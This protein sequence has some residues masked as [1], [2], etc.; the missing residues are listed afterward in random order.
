MTTTTATTRAGTWLSFIK[1]A[2]RGD[3]Y[4]YTTGSLRKAVFLLAVPMIIE[5]GMESVFAIVDLFFVGKLGKHAVT[6]VGLTESVLSLVY[7]LAIGLSMGATAVV[8]RRIG[9]KDEKGA[10]HAA[11]QSVWIGVALSVVITIVGIYFSS[12]LLKLMGAEQ[13]TIDKGSSYTRIL[14]ASSLPIILL[15]LINGIFR[16]AGNA[17]I[18]MKSLGLANLVN[19]I[20]CPVLIYGLGPIPAMGLTGAA[21]A[22]SIGRA[23]GVLYQLYHLFLGKGMIRLNRASFVIDWKVIKNL[24]AIGWPATLQFII[25]SC[26]WIF[27]AR[28][29]A[30]T[31]HSAAS[32]GYQTAMRIIIF[33]ILPAW[34]ISNASATLVGQNLG[35]KEPERAEKAVYTTAR[36]NA[37]FMIVVS[38]LFMVAARPIAGFFTPLEEVKDIATQA[39]RIISVGYVFYGIGMVLTSAFNGAGDTR[40]PTLI[41]VFGFWIIQIPLA[42]SLAKLAGLGPTGVFM[43]I[44]IAE[45]VITI[46]AYILFRQGRWKQTKV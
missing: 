18:A 9:E 19:I 8:S 7:S 12:D 41:N 31:G 35:A 30:E 44:P 20:L 6:T 15:F 23:T 24:L 25:G 10:G 38:L 32:A 36:Y 13:E 46:T 45:T 2:L 28:L 29:V 37:L 34:G 5:M 4:D 1:K 40:T 39:L 43:A 17:A 26:S 42:Y 33:F 14:F 11:A 27:M 21:V 16:G 22:T 3:E